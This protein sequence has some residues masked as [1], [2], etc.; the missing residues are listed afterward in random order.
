[1]RHFGVSLSFVPFGW[2]EGRVEGGSLLSFM[3]NVK[4]KIKRKGAKRSRTENLLWK[5]LN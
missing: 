5:R 3:S 2:G 4:T 1:L